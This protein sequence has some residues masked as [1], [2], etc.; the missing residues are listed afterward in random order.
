M[1][2]HQ[3]GK[4]SQYRVC[5]KH[6]LEL[7]LCIN[8][9][10]YSQWSS[11]HQSLYNNQDN[12]IAW[13]CEKC[14]GYWF[15]NHFIDQ[16]EWNRPYRIEI[17]QLVVCCPNCDS[18]RVTHTC[19][20]EC[21]GMHQCQDCQAEFDSQVKLVSEG[22]KTPG[23]P[24]RLRGQGWTSSGRFRPEHMQRTGILRNYRSCGKENHGMLEV[25]LIAPI[26]ICDAQIGWYCEPCDRVHYEVGG[27][28]TIRLE[29]QHEAHPLALCP[30]CGS[31]LLDS[32]DRQPGHG[33]CMRCN[34]EVQVT[35]I[36]QEAT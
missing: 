35:L 34:T 1:N 27:Q 30:C 7:E 20:P 4:K 8:D 14:I 12:R 17:A 22:D 6:D 5:P 33:C 26:R 11:D 36:A 31:S 10:D 19:V 25:V 2:F 29:F 24:P 21:C 32:T 23:K 9:T 28:R 3:S 15:E 13:R 18:R 16:A